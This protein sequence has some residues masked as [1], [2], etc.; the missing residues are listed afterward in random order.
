VNSSSNIIHHIVG[1][2]LIA[3]VSM[4][5]NAIAQNQVIAQDLP[6]NPLAI[7]SKHSNVKNK[8]A[9]FCGNHKRTHNACFSSLTAALKQFS[10]AAQ[11]LHNSPENHNYHTVCLCFDNVI[12]AIFSTSNFVKAFK[13]SPQTS[14]EQNNLEATDASL[15]L[16]QTLLSVIERFIAIE[17]GV[18]L[19][20][21]LH[22]IA[23]NNTWQALAAMCQSLAVFL[24]SKR[25]TL[26]KKALLC[27]VLA[28]EY[29]KQC[30]EYKKEL[31]LRNQA[32]LLQMEREAEA[33][34]AQQ[35]EEQ[36]NLVKQAEI[37]R[38]ELLELEEQTRLAHEA[39]IARLQEEQERL[40]HEA[41]SV[42]LQQDEQI[43][44]AH[45]AEIAR[46][47]EEQERLT[48]IANKGLLSAIRSVFP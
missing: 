19:D 36:A 8:K 6:Q 5:S 44:L 14:L 39:E 40:A 28:D 7:I 12:K 33:L 20:K 3:S 15:L 25:G 45:E 47:Q 42:R 48:K 4:A 35:L 46:L 41:E 21:S 24:S 32:H 27:I 23:A 29:T 2:V 31:A 30:N 1:L 13:G 11:S 17:D 37:A 10:Q 9:C 26:E 18:I 22:D 16:S 34:K 38:L 43:R